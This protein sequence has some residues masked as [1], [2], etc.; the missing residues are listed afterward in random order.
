[1]TFEEELEKVKDSIQTKLIDREVEIAIEE[2]LREPI[3]EYTIIPVTGV[4]GAKNRIKQQAINNTVKR[5][6][7]AMESFIHNMNTMHS[8]GGK[9]N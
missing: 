7:Q 3:I 1:M 4:A 9:T 5:V 2:L 8:R 6:H